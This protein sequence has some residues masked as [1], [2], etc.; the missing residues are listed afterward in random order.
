VRVCVGV[1]VFEQV[2]ALNV[3]QFV[4]P[5]SKQQLASLEVAGLDVVLAL[6]SEEDPRKYRSK[7]EKMADKM[8]HVPTLR[9]AALN[10]DQNGGCCTG[11]AQLAPQRPADTPTPS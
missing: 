11:A 1:C 10:L 3:A 5:P 7:L 6:H 8:A 2:V 4:S 9:F